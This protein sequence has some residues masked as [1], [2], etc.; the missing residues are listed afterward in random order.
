MA[1]LKAFMAVVKTKDTE[2]VMQCQKLDYEVTAEDV[3]E[4]RV[5]LMVTVDGSCNENF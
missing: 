4:A 1:A 2:A 5:T 3:T